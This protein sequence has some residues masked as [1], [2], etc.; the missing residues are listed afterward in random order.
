LISLH[1]GVPVLLLK[2]S[3][4]QAAMDKINHCQTLCVRPD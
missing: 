4:R 3:A 1:K 2:K